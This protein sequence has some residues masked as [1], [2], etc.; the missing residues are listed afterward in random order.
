MEELT[1]MV[2]CA[3]CKKVRIDGRWIKF[4]IDLE[5]HELS[6]GICNECARQLYPEYID[7]V[8]AS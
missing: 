2:Q 1:F 5:K 6:H 7:A 8:E 4:S 3:N